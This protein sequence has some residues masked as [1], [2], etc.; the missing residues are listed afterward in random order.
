M[1]D[2]FHRPAQLQHQ[3][4]QGSVKIFENDH[5]IE[6]LLN[7]VNP[8]IDQLEASLIRHTQQVRRVAKEQ[9]LR[10]D[11][12]QVSRMRV[13]ER[14]QIFPGLLQE[15]IHFAVEIRVFVV[16]CAPVLL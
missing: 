7:L 2:V 12:E 1:H 16:V 15:L 13:V 5:V 4:G 9:E 14:F 8:R 11:D 3:N 10:I 6:I